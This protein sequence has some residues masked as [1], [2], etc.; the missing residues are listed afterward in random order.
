MARSDPALME[1]V[2][3]WAPVP[4]CGT[5]LLQRLVT[6]SRQVLVFGEDAFL[7]Q[8]LPRSLL[9]RHDARAETEQAAAELASGNLHGW[10]PAALPSFQHYSSALATSF[11]AVCAAYQAAAE[12]AGFG[13]WGSKFPAFSAREYALIQ[14]LLPRSRHLFVYRHLVDALASIKARKW[15][16][17]PSDLER[18]CRDWVSRVGD[19]LEMARSGE[20]PRLLAVRYEW[21][22]SHQQR[23]AEAIR[24]FLG[25]ER[26]DL[27]VFAH[28]VNT[29]KGDEA[30]GFSRRQ[31][32]RPEPLTTGELA[33]VRQLAGPLL[34]KL[35]YLKDD[36]RKQAPAA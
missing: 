1:A 33:R 36:D 31:Y 16:K 9:A 25:L 29:F 28:R 21:L 4:R 35:G 24:E 18:F 30:R 3:I 22:C 14:S 32:I 15:L 5:G 23:E 20:H 7:V 13:R 34:E 17:T 27:E 8:V 26:L 19:A 11:H 2:F 10:F 6:S 12:K